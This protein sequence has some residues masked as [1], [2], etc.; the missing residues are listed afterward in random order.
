MLTEKSYQLPQTVVTNTN[1][2]LEL[3]DKRKQSSDAAP[4]LNIKDTAKH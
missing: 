2:I 1:D 4:A 3:E